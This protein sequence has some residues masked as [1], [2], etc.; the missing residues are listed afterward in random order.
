MS[1]FSFYACARSKIGFVEQL[2][3]GE[4]FAALDV[5]LSGNGSDDQDPTTADECGSITVV[6]DEYFLKNTIKLSHSR[7]SADLGGGHE[8]IWGGGVSN[9]VG[10]L[11]KG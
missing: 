10:G 4:Q 2:V 6:A 5:I 1:H 11:Q 9:I 8:L 3:S 7:Y